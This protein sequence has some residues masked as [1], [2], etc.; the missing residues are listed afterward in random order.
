MQIPGGAMLGM[1]LAHGQLV[2]LQPARLGVI[3]HGAGDHGL[4]LALLRLQA[5]GG[6]SGPPGVAQRRVFR[7]AHQQTLGGQATC[8]TVVGVDRRGFE[9]ADTDQTGGGGVRH[10]PGGEIGD[11]AWLAF[12][13]LQADGAQLRVAAGQVGDEVLGLEPA[14]LAPGRFHRLQIHGPDLEPG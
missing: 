2:D 8:R 14:E 9:A 12:E 4:G 3:G 11:P 6:Q 5:V 13:L 10:G 7:V 1:R